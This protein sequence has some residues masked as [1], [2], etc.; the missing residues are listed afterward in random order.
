MGPFGV[1]EMIIGVVALV[2]WLVPIAAGIWALVTLQRLRTGQD[3]I[4]RQLAEIEQQLQGRR[5]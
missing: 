4:R 1:P 3:A 5:A 2:F